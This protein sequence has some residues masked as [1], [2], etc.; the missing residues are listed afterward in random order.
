MKLLA[1]RLRIATCFAVSLA[2][3]PGLMANAEN[4]PNT[5]TR[6]ESI[7]GW[8]LLFDGKS[9]TGW[10]NYKKDK[11]S[12]GWK[13]IDGALVREGSGA[14]DIITD[15]KYKYFELSLDYNIS[16]G[17]N[18]GL[19]FHVTEDNAAPWQSGPEVQIQDNIDGHDPQKSGWLYQMFKPNPARWAGETEIPD[20]TRPPGEWNQLFLRISPRGCEVSMNGVSYYQFRLGDDRWKDLVSK[21]KFAQYPGFGAAGEGYV[22]LQDHGNAISFRNIKIRE[23][24][25][26]GSID[27]P[28]DGKLAL[29][30][31]LAFPKLKWEGWQAVDEDGTVNR[32]LRILELTHAK[33]DGKRLFVLDQGG[34]V[35]TI[36]NNPDVELAKRFLDIE[37]RVSRWNAPGGNEQGLLGLAFH[38]KFKENGQFFVNYTRPNTH[39]TVISR[40]RIDAKDPTKADPKSEEVLLEIPQPFQ[41]HNGGPIEFGP[42]GYLY[43]ATG[44]GGAR[45]D[46][47]ANGQNLSQSL[48]SILRIDVDSKSPGKAY[49]IPADNPF[50][51]TEGAKPEIFAYGLRNPWRI[52]FDKK[53][54]K[55][56]CADVGQD[57]WEEINIIEKGG[58]YGWSV[59][60]GSYAFGKGSP[61]PHS[62]K[63]IDP[64][65]AYDHTVGKSIT[66]GRVYNS[67]RLPDLKGKYLYAD[68]VSGGIWALTVKDGVAEA[69]RN[70]EVVAGGM[71]VLAFGEDA[72]GEVYFMIDSA[73]GES[74][75]KFEKN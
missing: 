15:G 19:M 34:V 1:L 26:D 54:G 66:G 52:G 50:T 30:P 35:Y 23:L 72:N 71:P 27:P 58:N 47:L 13:V 6:A 8:K 57:L 33:G 36:E 39:E 51:K 40:F 64:V 55:L 56:W 2:L 28:V 65:W 44:D 69:V 46:P 70:E 25:E 48:G 68:Y 41:N 59:R 9:T 22:S 73:R 43:I 37:D 60:E 49:G 5:L 17:G 20:A 14:G 10:R 7:S 12:D 18:S 61:A 75:Y 62:Q 42:D 32:P 11:I 38:P 67:D 4:P 74:I 29:R 63:T 21:S 53:T 45:N 16:Q 24:K 3:F 31:T